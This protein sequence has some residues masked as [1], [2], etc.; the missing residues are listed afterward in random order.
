MK[1]PA[2]NV[3][4]AGILSLFPAWI[5]LPLLLLSCGDSASTVPSPA[6]PEETLSIV[7]LSP[8][9]SRYRTRGDVRVE[10]RFE[11]PVDPESVTGETFF[12][13]AGLQETSPRVAGTLEVLDDRVRF[14]PG[15]RLSFGVPYRVR[16]TRGLRSEAGHPCNGRF[17]EVTY[18]NTDLPAPGDRFVVN[19][20]DDFDDSSIGNAYSLMGYLP[21][22]GGLDPEE[23][24]PAMPEVIPGIHATE[25]WKLSK[26]RPD[27]L[28]VVLDNG[29][30]S[31]DPEDLAGNLYLNR[32]ELP[33]PRDASGNP[34][35]QGAAGQDPYDFNGDGRFNIQDYREAGH[36]ILPGGALAPVPDLNGNGAVDPEDLML[37]FMD[38]ADGYPA[39]ADT[40]ADTGGKV[41]DI[42]GY[43]FFRQSPWALGMPDFP[44]GAH[45]EDRARE[46]AGEADNGKGVSGACPGCTVMV[47]R[48]TYALI[49]EGELVSH[50]M[51]YAIDKGADVIVAALGSL[52]GTATEVAAFE[53]ADA[54]GVA[55]IVG[56]SDESSYHH[57]TPSVF[58]HGIAAKCNYAFFWE[59]FCTGY[60]GQVH[61]AAN[62]QCGSTACGMSG[63][64]A[65]LLVSRARDLGY[66]MNSRPEDPSC[67]DPDLTGNEVKQ[68]L[69]L[70]AEKPSTTQACAGFLT[71]A[72]CKLDTWDRHQ[73]YGRLNLFRALHRLESRPLPAAVQILEPGW[74]ALLNPALP[75][76][77]ALNADIRARVPVERVTCQWAPGIEPDESDFRDMACSYEPAAGALGARLPLQDMAGAVGGETLIPDGPEGKAVTVRV[78]AH[79]GS[80]FGEDRR[81]FAVHRDP[82]WMEGF[83]VS[84]IDRDGD[85]LEDVSPDAENAFSIEA[86]PALAD[87]DGDGRDEI[88]LCTSNGQLHVLSWSEAEG[89]PRERD[90]YP[91][92]FLRSEALLD[93]IGG[94]PA[95]GDID[96]DG[97]PDIVVATLGGFLYA[98]RGVDALPLGGRPD[99][100]ILAADTPR[101]DS[102]ESYGAG[103]SFFG[104]PVLTDLNRDGILDVVAGCADQKVYAVD[105]ASIARGEAARLP[106]WPVHPRDPRA[107]SQLA[108]SILSTVAAVDLTG[109]GT[110]EIVVG[111]SEACDEP[112]AASGRLYA[113]HPAGNLE[114]L[115]AVLPGF[116]VPVPPNPLGVEIPLPPLTT[117]VPGSPVAARMGND[118]LIGAG[119]F[120][121][122]H[123]VVH[124]T[125]ET[126]AVSV[127]RLSGFTFGAAGSGAF[128]REDGTGRAVYAIPS[129]TIGAG[130]ASGLLSLVKQVERFLP[131]TASPAAGTYPMEDYQFLSNPGFVDVDGDGQPEIVAPSGGHFVHAYTPDGREPEGWPKFTY[132]WHM[133]SPA[134]GDLDGD[135][136]LEMVAPVREG[137]IF[138]WRTEAPVCGVHPW[139]TF[140]HDNRRTGNLDA[141]PPDA[142]CP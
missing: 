41:D 3:S 85:I 57:S 77:G 73:G 56:M 97:F 23:T 130:G 107:C 94:A 50:A 20:A 102:P 34:G 47:C 133:A 116:P 4:H 113:L 88:V 64:A 137:R 1:S 7:S 96:Q 65:G 100:R 15:Q 36:A 63:G 106:G 69:T 66:C 123:L 124:V 105:G 8:D 54:A 27:V 9:L 6:P 82:T 55:V 52:S 95:V 11:E 126:G 44:E 19:L 51:R 115:G 118:V 80:V 127:E 117:G 91:V 59:S 14:T 32:G 58:N 33:L 101:N 13:T 49:E 61:F 86:S 98:F 30:A 79:A 93:G 121:G 2:R 62:G 142:P 12:L 134:F 37:A 87:L 76:S 114:P 109:D 119:T 42:S 128:R 78:R 89:A 21:P 83:P 139:K 90:G 31:Y 35:G 92:R 17:P 22:L 29:L 132:G 68:V 72:S 10:V 135:G 140:H 45:G 26:G 104:S 138:A 110:D 5:L 120:L 46:V 16:V 122:P 131:G 84:L 75:S 99:G 103:N 43:D 125:P 74:F 81:V 18:G 53:E 38:G 39:D 25:A 24:D 136:M 28:V 67:T 70:T 40:P 60:G 108:S 112:E 141:L 111:T 71:D 129:V 48:V